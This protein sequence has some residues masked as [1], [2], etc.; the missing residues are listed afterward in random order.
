MRR[1]AACGIAALLLIA[2]GC[3]DSGPDRRSARRDPAGA[4]RTSVPR[5]GPDAVIRRWSDSLRAGDVEA[6]S[7]LFS[8]PA[9]VANG[10]APE[11]LSSRA[12]V[13]DF[14]AS[15]PCGAR[16]L[17]TR[18]EHAYTIATFRL[19]KRRG[20]D[21]GGGVGLTAD[22]AFVV[23]RGRIREWLRLPDPDRDGP[24]PDTS[25]S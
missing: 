15:L 17:R 8:L 22:T 11:R 12:A 5:N 19:T 20:G 4:R 23:H 24:A 6:A 13:R 1:A 16:L 3:G 18:R 7:R 25:T 9:T 10:T 21:C 14:N 2:A